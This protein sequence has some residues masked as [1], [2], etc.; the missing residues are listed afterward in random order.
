MSAEENQRE[1]KRASDKDE[2]INNNGKLL[3]SRTSTVG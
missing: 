1:W 2:I 3:N